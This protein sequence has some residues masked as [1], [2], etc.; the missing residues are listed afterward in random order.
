MGHRIK[1]GASQRKQ[2]CRQ[3]IKR[4]Y[5]LDE[6]GRFCVGCLVDARMIAALGRGQRLDPKSLWARSNNDT[7]QGLGR[8]TRLDMIGSNAVTIRDYG[9]TV[10]KRKLALELTQGGFPTNRPPRWL[11]LYGYLRLPIQL[12]PFLI[13][14]HSSPSELWDRI[15]NGVYCI[16]RNQEQSSPNLGVVN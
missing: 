10:H 1:K 7:R 6:G 9:T 15:K 14:S 5:Y 2:R 13:L 3:G 11:A 16:G 8:I 12:T 4:M